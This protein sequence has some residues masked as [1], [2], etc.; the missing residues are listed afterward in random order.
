VGF[1]IWRMGNNTRKRLM[2]GYKEAQPIWT[3]AKLHPNLPFDPSYTVARSVHF[4]PLEPGQYD[5]SV[6]SWNTAERQAIKAKY[7]S[8]DPKKLAGELEKTECS[9]VEV[10]FQIK[11]NP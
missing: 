2:T 6:F 4:D 1:E 7:A 3:A 5:F 8:A 9:R 10:T 11:V